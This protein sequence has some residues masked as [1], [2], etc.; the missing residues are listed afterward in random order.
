[1]ADWSGRPA[2]LQVADDLRAGILN[3]RFTQ[4]SQLPSYG[5]LMKRYG[6]SITVVRSAIRELR[7]ES[8]VRTHQGKGVF[9][10]D[11]LPATRQ[12]GPAPS[13][14]TAAQVEKLESDLAA[15]RETVALLQAQLIDLYHSTGHPYPYEE[16]T[17]APGRQAG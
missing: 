15:L 12:T 14:G 1:M 11:Q 8:L 5:V 10:S 13:A 7:T 16:S 3:G 6:V 9:V 17:A 2:Y 4:G